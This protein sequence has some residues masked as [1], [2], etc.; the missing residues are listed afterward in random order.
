MAVNNSFF[1]FQLKFSLIL[2]SETE[3]RGVLRLQLIGDGNDSDIEEVAD[4]GDDREESVLPLMPVEEHESPPRPGASSAPALKARQKPTEVRDTRRSIWKQIPF[5]Q[6]EH[7]YPERLSA[8]VGSPLAYFGDYFD[9][10]FFEHA[11]VCT[12]NYYMC[13]T[14]KVLNTTVAELKKFV[15][16]HFIMGCIP[17]PRIHMD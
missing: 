16:I 15:R 3:L 11:A 8:V 9:D 1:I 13:K 2:L 12:N 7:C 14:G 4:D 10:N 17:S 5:N 6:K